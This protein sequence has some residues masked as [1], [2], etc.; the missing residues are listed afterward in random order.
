MI[1]QVC[2]TF[3]K[4]FLSVERWENL[5]RRVT[6]RR[7]WMPPAPTKLP[8][9]PGTSQIIRHQSC[10]A[11]S[12]RCNV[13]VICGAALTE[14][15]VQENEQLRPPG[16]VRI[17]NNYLIRRSEDDLQFDN[18]VVLVFF[19]CKVEHNWPVHSRCRSQ[20]VIGAARRPEHSLTDLLF[21]GCC[22]VISTEHD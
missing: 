14:V 15:L 1:V 18:S 21:P 13:K 8:D 10:F 2:P 22:R 12:V 17:F 19:L 16:P 3:G 6:P 5:A 20:D 9:D 7:R 4:P 11:R